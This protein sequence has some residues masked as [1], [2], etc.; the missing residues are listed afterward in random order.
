M[1]VEHVTTNQNH[2]LG[3]FAWELFE[4]MSCNR[5]PWECLAICQMLTSFTMLTCGVDIKAIDE[6]QGKNFELVEEAMKRIKTKEKGEK[7]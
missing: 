7:T 2:D 5:Q 6:F 3:S 4:L 1:K